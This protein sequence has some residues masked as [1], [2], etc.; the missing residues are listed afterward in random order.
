[1]KAKGFCLSAVFALISALVPLRTSAQSLNSSDEMREL[2]N[3]VEELRTQMSKMQ[4][5]IDQLK[6]TK[7]ET[8]S[9]QPASVS[10]ILATPKKGSLETEQPAH[11][12]IPSQQVGEA[13][14]G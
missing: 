6:D 11:E 14:A 7:L 12:S 13:T 3:L 8:T 9:Q 10:A 4:A 5:E 2:R 1:M